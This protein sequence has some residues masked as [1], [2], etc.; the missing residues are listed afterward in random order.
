MK[1]L[2]I[3]ERGQLAGELK[4]TLMPVCETICVDFPDFDITN[5]QIVSDSIRNILPDMVINASAYTNVDKAEIEKDLAESVNGKGP[6]YVAKVCADLQI[7]M[8][9]FSTDFVFNGKIDR[10][11]L[12]TDI[13][14]PLSFYGL[15]KLHGEQTIFQVL[16][17]ALVFRLAWLYTLNG[18]A[19]FVNKFQQWAMKKET[20]TIVDDQ[21]GNPTWA[22]FVAEAVAGVINEG[23]HSK[24]SLYNWVKQQ[25]GI[26]HLTSSGEA[27]RYDWACRI[28]E[29]TPDKSKFLVKE[30]KRGKTVD[31]PSIA[32]RPAYSPL[33][34]SKFNRTFNL[35]VPSWENQL[36]LCLKV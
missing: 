34:C 25:S 18:Q 3:G 9:H 13:P 22:R 19:S 2:I 30:I 4:R 35:L 32:I 7:P 29:L 8:I 20:L 11:Y 10:P 12:E 5:Q 26:Y 14:D 21:I 27:S 33:N 23:I 6:G 36:N 24:L 15:T 28:L 16:D 1:T 17:S 31:F